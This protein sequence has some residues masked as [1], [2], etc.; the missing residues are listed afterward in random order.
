MSDLPSRLIGGSPGRT[1]LQLL[2]LSLVVGMVL[3]ALDLS[4]W[5]L[6]GWV[7]DSISRI[8]H[9]GFSAIDG[10][11]RDV[12]IGAAVVI[13]VWVVVRLLSVFGKK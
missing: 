4:P 7:R 5:D 11:L 12:L 2:V 3:S 1:F 13:P 8:W 9:F 10:L 6:V